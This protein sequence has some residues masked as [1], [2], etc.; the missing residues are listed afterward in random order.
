MK[1]AKI[2]RRLNWIHDSVLFVFFVLLMLVSA[3]CVY[4]SWYVYTHTVERDI[5]KYKPTVKGYDPE[6]SP[7][8]EDMAGWLTI[9]GTDI[10]YPVMH[11]ED[12]GRYLNTDPYGNYSLAGSIFLD[13]SNSPDFSDDYSIIYGHHM[14]YGKMF[15]ALDSFLDESY[16]RSHSTGSLIVGR[17]GHMTYG[18]EVFAAAYV[19][20]D[21]KTVFSIGSNNDIEQF[22]ADN[23]E[24]QISV[25]NGRIVALSTCADND[26]I[27]RLVVFCSIKE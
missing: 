4:D 18:L 19:S 27:R 13:S 17:D 9:D 24:V 3:Y 21:E 14:Q 1:A 20:A 10:D 26:S 22:I 25:P 11:C 7:L 6:T 15:G 23:A 2:W 12:N 8:T 16:M 5:L